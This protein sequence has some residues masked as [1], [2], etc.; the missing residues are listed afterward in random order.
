M[1]APAYFKSRASEKS[2]CSFLQVRLSHKEDDNEVAAARP[3]WAVAQL[4]VAVAQTLGAAAKPAEAAKT[5]N[6]QDIVK[7]ILRE[8]YHKKHKP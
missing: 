7:P 2:P 5:C 3:A 6:H 8:I 4:V 1:D